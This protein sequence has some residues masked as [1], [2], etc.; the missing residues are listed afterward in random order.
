MTEWIRT[1]VMLLCGSCRATIPQE[2]PVLIIHL[3]GT[4]RA[5]C[6]ACAK[7]TFGQEPPTEWPAEAIGH[8]PQVQRQ[9]DFVTPRQLHKMVA[10]LDWKARQSG[11]REP[12]EEG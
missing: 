3:N 7:R 4:K 6:V 9:P 11:E 12:G 8:A 1:R 10:R 2:T 5:R